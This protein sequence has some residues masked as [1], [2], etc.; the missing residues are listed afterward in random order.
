MKLLPFLDRLSATPAAPAARR[1]VL[2]RLGQA[3][4]AAL[5]LG[6]ALVT[7]AMAGPTNTSLDALTLLVKLEDLQ[8]AFYTQAVAAPALIGL[9]PDLQ[10]ILRH[11]QDHARFL[12]QAFQLST[13][14]A[15]PAAPAFDFSRQRNAPANPVLFPDTFTT[16]SGFFNL[17]QQIEDAAVAIYKSQVT[18]LTSDRALFDAVLRMHHVEAR[19][20][21]HLRLL[22]HRAL[23]SGRVKGWPSA[24]DA[25]PSPAVQVPGATAGTTTS[26][27]A[28]EANETQVLSGPRLAPFPTLLTGANSVQ[29]NALAEAFDES[30]PTTQAAA[31]LN[32]FG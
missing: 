20:A 5:P 29:F 32:A 28:F 2:Q 17:A 9:R 10:R 13:G 6:A 30:L 4:A 16:F 15:A 23:A 11:Q 8:S 12:R 19:H 14:G 27:Y 26:I 22:R 24:A 7:P 18:L 25:A 31:F 21:A 3:A 1:H